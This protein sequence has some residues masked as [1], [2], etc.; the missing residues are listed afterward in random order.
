MTK[1][2]INPERLKPQKIKKLLKSKEEYKI[3]LR[4]QMVYLISQ[5]KSSREVAEIYQVS[6]KNV[7]NWVHRFE[8]EGI[9]GLKDKEGR[10]RKASLST[11]D[12]DQI[13]NTIINIS[14][15]EFGYSAE[16]W[17]GPLL[18]KWVNEEYETN[19]TATTIYKLLDKIGLEFQNG[20]GFVPQK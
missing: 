10:G 15:S 16:R 9:E 3:A 2:T 20:K 19:F 13:K 4:L 12:Q 14:P 11:K 18:L 8:K 1:N 17:T 6:F 7:L 5:G